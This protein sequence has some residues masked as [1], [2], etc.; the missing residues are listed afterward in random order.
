MPCAIFLV[1]IKCTHLLVM[2]GSTLEFSR[3]I[4]ALHE[5]P[6]QFIDVI[7]MNGVL[8]IDLERSIMNSAN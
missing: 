6:Y 1:Q 4:L 8:L 2:L 5:K 7:N 3:D